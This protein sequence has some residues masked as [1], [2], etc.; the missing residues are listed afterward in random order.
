MDKELLIPLLDYLIKYHFPEIKKMQENG[1]INE[2]CYIELYKEVVNRT[3]KLAALWQCYGFCHGVL[4]TDNLS[5]LGLTIDFGPFGWIEHFDK[6]HVCNHSDTS[7]RY[8]Y[9]N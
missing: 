9:E 6:G 2:E 7:G 4:N 1:A 3:A 8:S 5:I